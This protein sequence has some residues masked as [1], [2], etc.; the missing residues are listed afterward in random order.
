MDLP[1]YTPMCEMVQEKLTAIF[2]MHGA[3]NSEPPILTPSLDPAEDTEGI[4]LLDK[5]GQVV[6]LANDGLVPF[7]RE[8]KRRNYDRIKR[9]QFF[10]A[11]R[12][13]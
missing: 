6:S 10:N 2:R 5:R 13:K 7:A 11:Y 9:F 12:P 4:L 8:A 3:I 1:E